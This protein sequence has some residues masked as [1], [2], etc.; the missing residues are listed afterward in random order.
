MLLGNPP[1]A[2]TRPIGRLPAVSRTLPPWGSISIILLAPTFA[3]ISLPSGARAIPS[4]IFRSLAS[5]VLSPVLSTFETTPAFLSRQCS[6]AMLAWQTKLFRRSYARQARERTRVRV[7]LQLWR[8]VSD[9]WSGVR[10]ELRRR[11][12]RGPRR[13]CSSSYQDDPVP[14]R[15]SPSTAPQ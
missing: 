4:G 6:T 11:P 10:R 7:G 1:G 12:I 8:I 2:P 3:T 9:C 13:D 14:Y 15:S 5:T